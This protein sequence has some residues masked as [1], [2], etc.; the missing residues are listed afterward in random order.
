M[1]SVGWVYDASK[2]IK[3]RKRHVF[4]DT[5]GR[6][7]VL[8]AHHAGVQD[9][10]GAGLSAGAAPFLSSRRS[11]RTPATKARASRIPSYHGWI[12]GAGRAAKTVLAVARRN[13]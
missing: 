12:G 11:S 3:G 7:L 6:G 2:K 10:D 5:D 9:R 13:G 8:F 4:V 1:R